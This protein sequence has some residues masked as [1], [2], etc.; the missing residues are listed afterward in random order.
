MQAKTPPYLVV[1]DTNVVLSALI[2]NSKIMGQ[3]RRLWARQVLIPVVCTETADELL[4]VLAHPKFKLS[5]DDI[6]ELLDD[7]LPYVKVHSINY[8]TNAKL[9]ACRDPKDQM[10]LDLSHSAKVDFL[11]T[12]DDDL[13]SLQPAGQSKLGFQIIKPQELLDFLPR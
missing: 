5:Q 8:K 9:P 6:H 10:F 4:R 1:H 7:Y 13:L 2:F 3:F 11:V 12:G